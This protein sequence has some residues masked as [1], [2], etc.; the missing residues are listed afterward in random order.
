MKK[1]FRLACNTEDW[2]GLKLYEKSQ[3]F[4]WFKSPKVSESNSNMCY[5]TGVT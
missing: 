5:T 2:A 3:D 1:F 4:L